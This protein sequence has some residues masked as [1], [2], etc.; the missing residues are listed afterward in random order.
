MTEAARN[1]INE[2]AKTFNTESK[3]GLDPVMNVVGNA[4]IVLLGKESHGT[5]DYYKAMAAIS[6]R[7]IREKNFTAIAIE[8]DYPETRRINDYITGKQPD[9]T[10]AATPLNP[11]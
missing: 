10:A 9:Q 11:L 5:G 1:Y 2:K 8:W 6:K 7:L 3:K 4:R